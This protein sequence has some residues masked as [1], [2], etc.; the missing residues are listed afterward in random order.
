MVKIRLEVESEVVEVI[1]SHLVVIDKTQVFQ[2]M[3]S[4]QNIKPGENPLEIKNKEKI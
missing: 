3:K 4:S 1:D 2:S